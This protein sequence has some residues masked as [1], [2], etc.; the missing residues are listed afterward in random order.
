[1]SFGI[2]EI[3]TLLLGMAGFGLQANPKA[4]TADQALQYAV[5]DADVAVHIDLA[6]IVPG[7]AKLLSQ[8]ADQPQIRASPELRK[9]VREAV[10]EIE[11]ARGM[12]K[13]ATGID[14]TTDVS[15]ATAFF[16]IVPGAEPSFVLAV[17]GRFTVANLDKIA[18]MAGGASSRV[19]SSPLVELGGTKPVIGLTRDNVLL[20]G[21][22]SLVRDRLADGWK[23]PS[24]DAGSSLGT[25]ADVI[26]TKPV[27][28]VVLT[29]SPAAR[30]EALRKLNG[31]GF[32]ADVVTRHKAAAF[33][34]FRDGIGWTW[35]DSTKAGLDAMEQVS[36]GSLDLLR[37]AQIAP[38]GIAKIA[39]GALESYRGTSPQLD[40]LIKHKADLTKIVETYTGDGSFKV[41]SD[42]NPRTLRLTVR[43]TGKTVSEVVP[44]GLLV[45]LA[46]VGYFQSRVVPTPPP[47][48]AVMVEPAKPAPAAKPATKPAPRP[49]PVTKPQVQPAKR[50]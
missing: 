2:I 3:I 18:K 9:R 29:M 27:L 39:I 47:T 49:V 31:P 46:I 21:T 23:A 50:P 24:H 1:M 10:G 25:L 41:A 36:N 20:I 11:G 4:P 12:A 34:V 42:K 30:A 40:D 13:L 7:N 19:G 15:D 35:I 32:A 45:P 38:R 22:P 37:A 14:V 26:T 43:A 44:F 5:A 16:R 17:H 6:S 8:L 28:A 48:G 33:S